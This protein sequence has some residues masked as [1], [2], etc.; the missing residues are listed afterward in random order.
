MPAEATDLTFSG[1]LDGSCILSL[2]INGNLGLS[3]SGE[4]LG[5]EV[6]GGTSAA[7]SILAV[8]TNTISITKPSWVS[9]PATY[10]STGEDLE[11][12]YSSLTA[13]LDQHATDYT[14]QDTQFTVTGL[15]LSVLTV[16]ARATN[17]ANGF[18]DGDYTM[19]V[20]VTCSA[21]TGT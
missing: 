16:N 10:V 21:G 2:P 14:D 18:V 3:T 5:T 4:V 8:G 12:A 20:T 6:G 13:L 19:K 9:A 7:I 1:H 11:V 15:P 17:T